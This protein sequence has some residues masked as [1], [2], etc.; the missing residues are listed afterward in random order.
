MDNEVLP[1]DAKRFCATTVSA[2]PV[3]LTTKAIMFL[4][5]SHR[6]LYGCF[7]KRGVLLAGVLV[8]GALVIGV[9]TYI[10]KLCK[11]P[12]KEWLW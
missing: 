2:L 4:G 5:S 11:E 7:N 1:A 9:Y 12:T 6:A 10:S 8:V 3:P